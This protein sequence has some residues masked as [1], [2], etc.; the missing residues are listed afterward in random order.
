M[1]YSKINTQIK[2]AVQENDAI[3]IKSW[4]QETPQ[5]GMECAGLTC[6]MTAEIIKFLPKC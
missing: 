3:N 5:T 4:D 2:P 1:V 6:K